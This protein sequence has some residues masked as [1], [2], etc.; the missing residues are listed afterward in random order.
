MAAPLT[1]HA[2]EGKK[3]AFALVGLGS[4]STNQIAPMTNAL[5]AIQRPRRSPQSTPRTVKHPTT[6]AAM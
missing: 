1:A 6:S 5:I 3:L 4:L 2:Q